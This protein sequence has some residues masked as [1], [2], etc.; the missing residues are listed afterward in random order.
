MA[1][2]VT[3]ARRGAGVSPMDADARRVEFSKLESLLG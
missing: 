3:P 1:L 2:A